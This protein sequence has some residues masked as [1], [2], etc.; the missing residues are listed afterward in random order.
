MFSFSLLHVS[1]VKKTTFIKTTKII[2]D[3]AIRRFTHTGYKNFIFCEKFA[4]N[5]TDRQN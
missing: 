3:P 5:C 1:G 4:L 2:I